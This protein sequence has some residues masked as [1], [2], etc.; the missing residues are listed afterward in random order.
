[1]DTR[2]ILIQ[3]INEKLLNGQATVTAEEDLLTTGLVD[4][5]GMMWLIGHIEDT[6]DLKIPP[7]DITIEHFLSV[8][9]IDA[10]LK[11]LSPE[12]GSGQAVER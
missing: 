11:S 6:Y 2:A 4:S 12:S 10:Y 3:Y 5:I 7:E 8:E 1:M 9:A